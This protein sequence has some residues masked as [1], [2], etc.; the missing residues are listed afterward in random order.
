ML[1]FIWS[2][3]F[4]TTSFIERKQVMAV[5][6]GIWQDLFCRVYDAFFLPATTSD[7]GIT[8]PILTAVRSFR[9]SILAEIRLV[10]D[11]I[12]S[13]TEHLFISPRTWLSSTISLCR[14]SSHFFSF[15]TLL[16]NFKSF[17]YT[18][19][20]FTLKIDKFSSLERTMLTTR[21]HLLTWPHNWDF[22]KYETFITTLSG[23]KKVRK[24]KPK[25]H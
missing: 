24:W 19:I 7:Y 23:S 17:F 1:H 25:D 20:T 22:S 16:V 12:T 13:F 18:H 3:Y 8:L 11:S 21:R 4:S 5:I 14:S 15:R 6:T 9:L 2:V 10:S